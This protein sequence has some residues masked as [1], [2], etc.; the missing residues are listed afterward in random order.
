[1]LLVRIDVTQRHEWEDTFA[2]VV[3]GKTIQGVLDMTVPSGSCR[4]RHPFTPVQNVL[5]KW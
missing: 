5:S 2:T 3:Q 1:V 4:S